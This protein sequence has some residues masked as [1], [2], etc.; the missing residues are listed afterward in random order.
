MTRLSNQVEYYWRN[1]VIT[2]NVRT[3]I[4]IVNFPFLIVK[5]SSERYLGVL[6]AYFAIILVLMFLWAI[7]TIF[8]SYKHSVLLIYKYGAMICDYVLFVPMLNLCLNSARCF[9]SVQRRHLENSYSDFDCDA[10]LQIVSSAIAVASIVISIMLKIGNICYDFNPKIMSR[11]F[12]FSEQTVPLV[13]LIYQCLATSVVAFGETFHW[14]LGGLILLMGFSLI[15][16]LIITRQPIFLSK[17]TSKF[18]YVFWGSYFIASMVLMFNFFMSSPFIIYSFTA[19]VIMLCVYVLLAPIRSFKVIRKHPMRIPDTESQ[20]FVF[21][22]LLHLYNDCEQI[23][24]FDRLMFYIYN[25][26]QICSNPVCELTS[27]LDDISTMHIT[28][29]QLSQF[30]KTRIFQ[31]IDGS[32]NRLI[33]N[34]EADET[35]VINFCFFLT[36]VINKKTLAYT[37]INQYAK[38]KSF[39]MT[40][41]YRIYSLKRMILTSDSLDLQTSFK[42]GNNISFKKKS[43]H[44]AILSFFKQLTSSGLDFW[45]NVKQDELDYQKLAKLASQISFNFESLQT[46]IQALNSKDQED[47]KFMYVYSFFLK[48]LFYKEKEADDIVR[49]VNSNLRSINDLQSDEIENFVKKD[50]SEFSVPMVIVDVTT[51]NKFT[52]INTNSLANNLFCSEDSTL[53]NKD[54]NYILPEWFGDIHNQLV[55]NYKKDAANRSQTIKKVAFGRSYTNNIFPLVINVK[56]LVDSINGNEYMLAFLSKDRAYE[57]NYYIVLDSCYNIVDISQ[58]CNDLFGMNSRTIFQYPE[59]NFW[60]KD[61]SSYVESLK[62]NAKYRQVNFQVKTNENLNSKSYESREFLLEVNYWNFETLNKQ[63][64]IVLMF[65]SLQGGS[66]HEICVKPVSMRQPYTIPVKEKNFNDLLDVKKNFN[67]RYASRSYENNGSVE[68]NLKYHEY[69]YQDGVK[70]TDK[71]LFKG[72]KLLVLKNNKIFE[73]DMNEVEKDQD[74]EDL[75]DEMKA[76]SLQC[77]DTEENLVS[78]SEKNFDKFVVKKLDE[79][80]YVKTFENFYPLLSVRNM[81]IFASVF[82]VIWIGIVSLDLTFSTLIYE[83]RVVN[84]RVNQILNSKM[85]HFLHIINDLQTMM[86]AKSYNLTVSS[87]FVTNTIMPKINNRLKTIKA[88]NEYIQNENYLFYYYERTANIYFANEES[89]QYDMYVLEELIISKILDLLDKAKLDD[90][91]TEFG[92]I[93]E[94]TFFI[95]SNTLNY[96]YILNDDIIDNNTEIYNQYLEQTAFL[97]QLIKIILGVLIFAFMMIYYVILRIVHSKNL[98]VFKALLL[99]SDQFIIDRIDSVNVLVQLTNN[100][101]HSSTDSKDQ[102]NGQ[103]VT[104]GTKVAKTYR[105]KSFKNKSLSISYKS[106]FAFIILFAFM[107]VYVIL[108]SLEYENQKVKFVRAFENNYLSRSEKLILMDYLQLLFTFIPNNSMLLSEDP[109]YIINDTNSLLVDNI[110]RLYIQHLLNIDENQADYISIFNSVF[111]TNYCS[112]SLIYTDD[113]VSDCMLRQKDMGNQG[114]SSVV[115][116]LQEEYFEF[117]LKAINFLGN[118][119]NSTSNSTNIT[120]SNSTASTTAI[121]ATQSS[122]TTNSTAANKTNA[123]STI[124]KLNA[125]H[126]SLLIF[127]RCLI[128]HNHRKRPWSRSRISSQKLPEHLHHSNGQSSDEPDYHR[129]WLDSPPLSALDYHPQY[130]DSAGDTECKLIRLSSYRE[131]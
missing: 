11:G 53:Y 7:S 37:F 60:I 96:Y 41:Q 122:N 64:Y 49:T 14:R 25:H 92:T 83:K 100:I 47:L 93:N 117:K 88:L 79:Q 38:K 61:I 75:K 48:I 127:I 95:V 44:N 126:F 19:M 106:I 15:I 9:I 105:K 32:F 12:Q 124:L 4:E 103:V 116:R 69:E 110:N 6:I 13:I 77:T 26:R 18:F 131:P 63:R 43:L 1:A 54:L 5:S 34:S 72:I 29:E 114:L 66:D 50:L 112:I 121:N 8:N 51:D 39:F 58:N 119:T 56:Y 84:I 102:D 76:F 74:K 35:L 45:E 130:S 46:Q 67:I 113:E 55:V 2:S 111:L 21:K 68:E 62:P 86:I 71:Y 129:S 98:R 65:G 94:I 59:A 89:K 23:Q 97:Q 99:L 22:Y 82:L 123:T 16:Y 73:F 28:G 17:N 20:V 24:R 27:I 78:Q 31:F 104:G 81:T 57:D 87:D 33:S 30:L 10:T 85:N 109:N 115:Y 120:S 42:K 91:L 101:V 118:S 90:A 108:F 52:I 3:A 70:L 128:R 125:S 36:E 40:D 107:G 80:T